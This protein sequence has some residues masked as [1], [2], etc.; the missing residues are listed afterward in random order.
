MKRY[1]R[2]SII[3]SR[4][5]SSV[6]LILTAN[7]LNNGVTFVLSMFI[8]RS[9][10]YAEFADYS[11]ATN[12]AMTL[13][14]VSELG[15]NV[16]M[17][18]LSNLADRGQSEK[19]ALYLENLRIKLVILN[20]ASL[21]ALVPSQLLHV[22]S[23][24][25]ESYWDLIPCALVTGG[26]LAVWGFKKAWYQSI[27]DYRAIAQ[28]ISTYAVTRL[29]F[30]LLALFY[31][32]RATIELI[33]LCAYLV[34]LSLTLLFQLKS[35]KAFRVVQEL[36]KPHFAEARRSLYSYSQP[37]AIG[38][39]AYVL[40]RN[41]LMFFTA[42]TMSAREVST[43]G[44][45]LT[46][47]AAFGLLNDA[48]QQV[49]LPRVTALKNEDVPEFR[50]RL[51]VL[52]PGYVLV[53][54]LAAIALALAVSSFLGS[55]YSSAIPIFAIASLGLVIPSALGFQ[56][57]LLHAVNRPDILAKFNLVALAAFLAM[58][59]PVGGKFGLLGLVTLHTVILIFTESLK[60]RALIRSL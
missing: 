13:F 53:C 7:L 19:Y 49:L 46:L 24:H 56:S 22:F 8:A 58:A 31:A 42:S 35:L 25:K 38:G 37:V 28:M 12:V 44:V 30:T 51:S 39:A 11:V 5:V 18:R 9:R 21:V 33:F 57:L 59:A 41:S 32:P 16:S 52:L 45:A 23:S 55:K 4:A 47:S 50:R 60:T 29:I 40:T 15:M 20:L 6:S 36:A 2:S 17:I 48:V 34:P 1:L 54:A 3:T 43:L 27:Q 14:A 26:V 10:S